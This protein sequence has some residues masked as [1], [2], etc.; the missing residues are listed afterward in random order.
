LE[1]PDIV[2]V[3]PVTSIMMLLLLVLVLLL[4]SLVHVFAGCYREF[5]NREQFHP[6][7]YQLPELTSQQKYDIDN[8]LPK[9]F[10]WCEQ[11]MCAPSWNQHIPQYCGSCYVHGSLASASDRIKIMNKKV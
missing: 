5:K 10:D 8:V 2:T 11:D 3:L 9:E 6:K 7:V 1:A 4:S